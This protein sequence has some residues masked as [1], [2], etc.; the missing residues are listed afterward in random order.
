MTKKTKNLFK[1]KFY[2]RPKPPPGPYT[3]P[4]LTAIK[5]DPEQ[6]ILTSCQVGGGYHNAFR[7]QCE[8]RSTTVLACGTP[9]RGIA[10]AIGAASEQERPS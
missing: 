7:S 6:A 2:A 3:K 8:S 9:I 4:R 1:R 10:T 5:L